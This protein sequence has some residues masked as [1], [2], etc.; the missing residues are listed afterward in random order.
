MI[1]SKTFYFVFTS[2]CLSGYP[3]ISCN[4]ETLGLM[5]LHNNGPNF[6]PEDSRHVIW[7][8]GSR[9]TDAINPKFD[10]DSLEIMRQSNYE[11]PE[12]QKWALESSLP[13]AKV[14]IFCAPC[15]CAIQTAINRS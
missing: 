3:G 11:F 13:L 10:Y 8:L 2:K 6:L 15:V 4:E 1:S 12:I 7:S 9:I 14:D 5:S